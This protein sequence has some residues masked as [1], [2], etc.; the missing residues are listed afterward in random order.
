MKCDQYLDALLPG[1]LELVLEVDVTG[2]EEGVD[3][4][5]RRVLNGLVGASDILLSGAGET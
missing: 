5:V 4:V 3:A 2:G 1:D